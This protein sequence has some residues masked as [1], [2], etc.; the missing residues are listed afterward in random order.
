MTASPLRVATRSSALAMWQA[1]HVASLLTTADPSLEV[2]FVPVTT[3]A[4][5]RLDVPIAE[6]GGKGVFAK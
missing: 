3:R 4:D 2:T 6:M 5:V 1:H